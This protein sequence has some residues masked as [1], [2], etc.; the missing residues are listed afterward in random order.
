MLDDDFKVYAEQNVALAKSIV[1][2]VES[3]AKLIN[4]DLEARGE[5]I[6]FNDPKTWKYYLNLAGEYYV[7]NS[8]IQNTSDEVMKVITTEDGTEVD[9]TKANLVTYSLTKANFDTYSDKMVER[10][11]KMENLI[12]RIHS[13]IDIDKAVN[14]EE[15]DIL[16][17]DESLVASN[18]LTLM[19]KIQK[20]IHDFRDR[21]F[22]EDF[23]ISDRYYVA[24]FLANMY[25]QL[26]N[27][28]MNIRHAA[29][30]TPE[31][32]QY[33][34]W[35]FLNDHYEMGK[36]RDYLSIK[37][38]LWLYRNMVDIQRNS[39]KK[40]VLEALLENITRPKGLVAHKFDFI[41]E[42]TNDMLN[43]RGEGEY[44]KR[45]FLDNLYDLTQQPVDDPQTILYKTRDKANKNRAEL[46]ADQQELIEKGRYEQKDVLPTGLLEF[47][48][49]NAGLAQLANDIKY[50]IE[51]WLYLSHMNMYNT[52]FT[53]DIPTAGRITLTAKDAFILYEYARFARNGIHTE[54][55]NPIVAQKVVS[56]DPA[57]SIAMFR[58]T[59]PAEYVTDEFIADT[60]A[61][62]IPAITVTNPAT[63]EQYAEA[64]IS[65]RIRHKQSIDNLTRLKHRAHH[66]NVIEG[67]Y[68]DY[69][70]VLE[71]VGTTYN[72]WLS[73]K[74][75]GRFSLSE[76]DWQ[77]VMLDVLLQCTGIDPDNLGVGVTRSAM[78]EIIDRLTSYNLLVVNG[79][80]GGNV[81]ELPLPF[82]YPDKTNSSKVAG[83]KQD[84]GHIRFIDHEA[85]KGS[86]VAEA[87][88]DLG[89]INTLTDLNNISYMQ[90]DPC[91]DIKIERD[92]S[93]FRRVSINSLNFNDDL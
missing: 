34:L 9:F 82:M 61:N 92:T 8:N 39:G 70:C 6:D 7:G 1:I 55:I 69:T 23:Q 65:R 17:Y 40:W 48:L 62:R 76:A 5:D 36:Y 32:D 22:K 24:S 63:L 46:L 43:S 12:Y 20:W 58:Q 72:E 85:E 14:A 88:I 50:R 89:D 13:P 53:F 41:K 31:V 25:L 16:F 49:S 37:T 27:V 93:N 79:A 73:N 56:F 78:I 91:L 57:I 10:Y 87:K 44:L 21:W 2:K 68:D 74:R 77:T 71:P 47:E 38:A 66:E 86:K 84:L 64:I 26:P 35:N 33:H 45:E 15:F 30:G 67:V 28:I 60:L 11:P 29:C 90:V 59:V 51:Y 83:V 3:A 4:L 19:E 80:D 18:E 54:L 75:I 52:N 81:N 42:D